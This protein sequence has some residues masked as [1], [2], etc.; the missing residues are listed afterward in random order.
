MSFLTVPRLRIPF[1]LDDLEDITEVTR[2]CL[3][4][5]AF[6]GNRFHHSG[7]SWTTETILS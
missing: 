4:V 1:P 5:F 2:M 3:D 7:T 6:H